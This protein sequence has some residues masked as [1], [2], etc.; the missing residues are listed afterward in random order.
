MDQYNHK[1]Y[2]ELLMVS[3]EVRDGKRVGLDGQDSTVSADRDRVTLSKARMTT[4]GLSICQVRSCWIFE[5]DQL[6]YYD[7]VALLSCY[8]CTDSL[9]S[10]SPWLSCDVCSTMARNTSG[11]VILAIWL[12]LLWHLAC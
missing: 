5:D 2:P 1:D 6:A 8:P 7:P 11:T 3:N 9:T 12:S 10:I 4:P